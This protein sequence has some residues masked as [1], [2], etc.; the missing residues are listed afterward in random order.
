M[1][2]ISSSMASR[3]AAAL[4]LEGWGAALP[5][6]SSAGAAA[7]GASAAA[8]WVAMYF[9]ERACAQ[10]VAALSGGRAGLLIAPEQAQMAVV[11]Q[12]PR[13]SMGAV[14][15]LAWPGLLRKLDRHM[16]GYDT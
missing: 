4:W 6:S 14:A 16:P 3:E 12:T 7:A 15:G 13:G 5:A 10:Q 11:S 2:T 1:R 8:A 9:L